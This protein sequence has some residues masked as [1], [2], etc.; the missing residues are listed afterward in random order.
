MIPMG[1]GDFI[2]AVN[3]AI[4]KAIRKQQGAKIDVR[5]E[6]E[7]KPIALSH[8]LVECLQDE[9]AAKI[10]FY[11]LPKSHQMY[12]NKWIESAKTEPTKAKRISQALAAMIRKKGFAEMLRSIKAKK[13]LFDFR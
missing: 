11:S 3:A 8:E 4:R 2:I 9:P 6:A 7:N 13:D 10:Y 12:F 1:S 5:L